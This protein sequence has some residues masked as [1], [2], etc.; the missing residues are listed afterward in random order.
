MQMFWDPE[1][2]NDVNSDQPVWC[3]GRSYRLDDPKC[4]SPRTVN[5]RTR[6]ADHDAPET[7][8]SDAVGTSPLTQN[9]LPVSKSSTN[10]P[11]TPPASTSSSLASAAADGELPP[12]KG[13][14][15]GFLEDMTSRFWMTYRSGFDPIPKSVDPRA[16]SALSFTV[17]IKSTLSD[18]TGF[19]S[20]SGWGCMI[21]SGQSLLATTIGIL[22]LGRDWRR[23]ECQQ[24]ERQLISMFA[25]D[26]RAPYSIHNF[27]RHGATACGKFPGE[28]FGPS[29][30]AQCIQAL[31]SSS[32][33]PL[34]VYSPSDGQD[35]YEDSFMKTAKP[36]GQGFH[37]T[38]ILIRTRLGIDKIT[39]IYWEALIAALQ[40]PQSVGIAG[41]RP[42]S[43]HYFVGSQGSYLFY[44]DPHHTRKAIPYHADVTKYTEEDIDSCHTSRLRRLHV[45]EMD[46]SMLIGFLIR[47]ESDWS[48][49]RRLVESV[50]GKTI[51]HVA[52]HEPTLYNSGGRDNAVDEVELLSD[53][54]DGDM[55]TT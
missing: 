29:A 37:P 41:G 52:D 2:S 19:S 46:P 21:R 40:M 39:P 53:D 26:P 8:G 31:T 14:P 10:A 20:D 4:S 51:I 45:R 50:Q 24:E 3:L 48:E 35:V 9:P 43:S 49:W 12:E 42:S 36:D 6:S 7:S 54:D 23:G 44:L 28:W 13:W 18:P 16:T 33:L 22:R 17:R 5:K 1:P 55:T 32:G 25:D 47:T 27:V 34:R 15:P 11:E 38:L 30:T